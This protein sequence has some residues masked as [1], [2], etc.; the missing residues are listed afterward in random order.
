MPMFKKVTMQYIFKKFAKGTEP[1]S[2]IFAKADMIF[3][4][5]FDT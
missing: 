3:E 2:I 1:N 4:L 5:N